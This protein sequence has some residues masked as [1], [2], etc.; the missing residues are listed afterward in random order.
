MIVWWSRLSDSELRARLEQ[1]D[2]PEDEVAFI[3]THR[4]DVPSII[5]EYLGDE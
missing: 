4:D 5:Q 2:V 1:R 3:V